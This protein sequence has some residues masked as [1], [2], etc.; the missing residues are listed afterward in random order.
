MTESGVSWLAMALLCAGVGCGDQSHAELVDSAG[1]PVVTTCSGASFDAT[2]QYGIDIVSPQT[3]DNPG[4]E[5]SRV[6]QINHYTG[7]TGPTPGHLSTVV[8]W[9]DATPGTFSCVYNTMRAAVS[10][11]NGTDFEAVANQVVHGVVQ[12]STCVIPSI[13]WDDVTLPPNGSRLMINATA[14]T[15][16]SILSPTRM[17]RV[18]TQFNGVPDQ[19]LDKSRHCSACAQDSCDGTTGAITTQFSPPTTVCYSASGGAAN[20]TQ[21]DGVGTCPGHPSFGGSSCP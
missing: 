10:R 7:N 4:C 13:T 8:S 1:E 20:V 15:G 17:V 18:Q 9:A 11:W 14:R 19:C 3:Y 12:G 6:Y 16:P 5:K 21:C 2:G